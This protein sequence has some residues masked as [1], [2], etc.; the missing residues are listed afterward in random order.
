[1][2]RALKLRTNRFSAFASLNGNLTRLHLLSQM[3]LDVE[4]AIMQPAADFVQIQSARERDGDVKLAI[5]DLGVTVLIPPLGSFAL[6]LD[7][8]PAWSSNSF[9]AQLDSTVGAKT[10]S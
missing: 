2:L 5:G 6:A 8:E 9:S 1:M 7:D 4:D 3:N 10:K